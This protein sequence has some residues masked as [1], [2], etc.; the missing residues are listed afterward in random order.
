MLF[1]AE[2]QFFK[3]YNE[4]PVQPLNTFPLVFS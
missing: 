3:K 1:E 2:N 4:F